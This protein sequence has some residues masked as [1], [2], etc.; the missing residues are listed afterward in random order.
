[1]ALTR[2]EILARKVHGNT[3]QFAL[4]D[5]DGG[6]VVIRGLTRNE[7]LQV[8]EGKTTGDMDNLMISLGMVDPVMSPE[9]VAAWGEVGD[10]GTMIRLSNRISELS[11]MVEG[12][13]KSGVPSAR[14]RPRS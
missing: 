8:R 14:K 9:D 13:G 4:G 5:G 12:A 2:D 10:A 3:E 11:G 6:Y 7:A 1:V